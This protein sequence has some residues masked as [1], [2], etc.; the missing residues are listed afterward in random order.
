[1]KD[2]KNVHHQNS[3]TKPEDLVFKRIVNDFLVENFVQ[4]KKYDHKY[5]YKANQV[6]KACKVIE[7]FFK[8]IIN[9]RENDKPNN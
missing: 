7:I 2:A 8:S 3:K 4:L 5:G 1:M 9:Y 6:G